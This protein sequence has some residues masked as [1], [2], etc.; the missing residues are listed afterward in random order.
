MFSTP[1]HVTQMN[2]KSLRLGRAFLLTSIALFISACD[3]LFTDP[4]FNAD[5]KLTSAELD[6][7][8]VGMKEATNISEKVHNCI[9]AQAE[10]MSWTP[11]Y[12]RKGFN[13]PQEEQSSRFRTTGGP[14][15]R[16]SQRIATSRAESCLDSAELT[17][18]TTW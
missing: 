9:K 1:P 8:L 6:Y 3:Q 7:F 12:S 4:P 17:C 15:N 10:R 16:C 14:E 5:G 2:E 11:T 18:N 13:F